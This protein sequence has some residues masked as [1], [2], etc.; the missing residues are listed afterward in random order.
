MTESNDAIKIEKQG[1]V[2]V[3][4][5]N[6]P[7]NLNAF[8][9]DQFTG[10][11]AALDELENDPEVYAVVVTG[12]GRIFCAGADFN[13][14][15]LDGGWDDIQ[16]KHEGISR[17]AGGILVL[18]LFEFTK[19]IICAMNGSAVGVG[20]TSTLPM[21]VRIVAEEGKYAFPFTRRGLVAESVSSWFLPRLVGMSRAMDWIV[22]GR[23]LN[24][25]E[26][27]EA[28]FAT[29]IAPAADVLGI[30]MDMANDIAENCS[31]NSIMKCKKLM[32]NGVIGNDPFQAHIDES[33]DLEAAF[34]S[35]PDFVEG[36]NSFLE[37]RKPQFNTLGGSDK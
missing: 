1:R 24:A 14:G 18:R 16:P 9:P 30:A 25:Q 29:R 10:Y 8:N 37:K 11:M 36:M 28:G 32:W 4:K 5:L 22:T 31:P 7:E 34:K 2:G 13:S 23:M 3:L 35:S 26:L 21:D 20:M 33:R 15:V 19:P 12:E 27:H 6:S 17:D